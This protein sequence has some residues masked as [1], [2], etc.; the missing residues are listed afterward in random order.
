VVARHA[1]TAIAAH[2]VNL[3]WNGLTHPEADPRLQDE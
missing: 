1:G 2:L 3:P